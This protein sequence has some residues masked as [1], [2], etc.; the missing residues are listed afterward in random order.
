MS[1]SSPVLG[2]EAWNERYLQNDTPWDLAGPTPELV[3]LLDSKRW[4]PPGHVLVPGGGRGHDAILFARHG[5]TVDLVDFAPS[6]IEAALQ[7]ASREKNA[8]LCLS[9][10]LL[11]FARSGLPPSELRLAF[12]IYV[13]LRHSAGGALSLCENSRGAA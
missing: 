7:L 9:P 10:Q 1:D 13:F 4:K 2:P 5:F 3:R 6:A 12:R 8:D 11:R